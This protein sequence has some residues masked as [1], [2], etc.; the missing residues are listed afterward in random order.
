YIQFLI[1]MTTYVI[2]D[3]LTLM[4]YGLA[5]QQIS[6]WLKGNPKILNTI[7]ACVLAIIALFIAV[8]NSF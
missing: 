5:A 3:F 8:T 2:L 4:M 1:L 7:S 6:L